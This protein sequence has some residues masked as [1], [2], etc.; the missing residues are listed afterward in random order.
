MSYRVLLRKNDTGEERW[1]VMD[2]DWSESDE[3][4]WTEGNFGCDCNRAME[5]ARAGGPGPPDDP[6]WN[7]IDRDCGDIAFTAICAE[8]ADGTIIK[9]DDV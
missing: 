9:L 5:W 2:F 3:F 7:N 8:L 6:H 1:R 4:W